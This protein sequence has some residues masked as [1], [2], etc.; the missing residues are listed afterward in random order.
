MDIDGHR[1]NLLK[2]NWTNFGVGHLG[3]MWY[4]SFVDSTSKRD[5]SGTVSKV[6]YT[7]RWTPEWWVDWL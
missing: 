2:K 6:G 4:Q 5:Y 1:K 7:G 3:G